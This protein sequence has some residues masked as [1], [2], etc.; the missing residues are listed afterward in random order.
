MYTVVLHI[1]PTKYNRAGATVR[2][3][4][5]KEKRAARDARL[6]KVSPAD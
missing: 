1:K 3:A 2:P 6:G 5:A 4:T